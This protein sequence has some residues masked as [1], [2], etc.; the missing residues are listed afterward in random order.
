MKSKIVSRKHVL[1]FTLIGSLALAVF[2]NW[3]YTKPSELNNQA[4]DTLENTNL[5][6]AQFVNGST[7]Q[8]DYFESA[9][10]NR[11]KAHD[12][13]KESLQALLDD[14]N[15]DEETKASTRDKLLKLSENIKLEAD[16]ENLITA[17][18]NNNCLVT[19]DFDSAE[20]VVPQGV[21]EENTLL[22]IKDII[23]SK[24][25]VSVEDITIIELK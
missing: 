21:I 7:L 13:A 20:V 22:K 9:Q 1:T 6:D 16:C 14:S 11:T 17:Q 15:V 10:M 18:I 5:G 3:Y 8:A 12:I 2:V 25:N 19:I 23:L 4:P 24:T